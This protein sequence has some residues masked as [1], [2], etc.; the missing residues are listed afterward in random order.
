MFV[1]ICI[2][3][4][5]RTSNFVLHRNAFKIGMQQNYLMKIE[6][7]K[8]RFDFSP[9]HDIKSPFCF[10][11]CTHSLDSLLNHL[12]SVPHPFLW[13]ILSHGKY[14]TWVRN[15]YNARF[16]V[17]TNSCTKPRPGFPTWS[18]ICSIEWNGLPSLFKLSFHNYKCT[19]AMYFLFMITTHVPYILEMT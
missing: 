7:V 1:S 3:Y 9:K 12:T 5:I 10:Q 18:I 6:Q 2:L 11:E 17:R 16:C 15:D 19:H 4:I 8:E 13:G 14:T